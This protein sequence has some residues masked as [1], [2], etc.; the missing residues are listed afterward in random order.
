MSNGFCNRKIFNGLLA[1]LI[2]HPVL[3]VEIHDFPSKFG[4]VLSD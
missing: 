2:G 4:R 1:K 3:V